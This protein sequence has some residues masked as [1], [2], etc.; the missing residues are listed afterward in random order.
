ME[1][2]PR[3]ENQPTTGLCAL[4]T[5]HR[6]R[7]MIISLSPCCV[8]MTSLSSS[9]AASSGPRHI[10]PLPGNKT[11][12]QWTTNYR[13]TLLLRHRIPPTTSRARRCLPWQR[14]RRHSRPHFIRRHCS[15][16]P[17][18]LSEKRHLRRRNC[19]MKVPEGS[20]FP[21]RRAAKRCAD[22]RRK[23]RV[24]VDTSALQAVF[25]LPFPFFCLGCWL[26]ETSAVVFDDAT[27][28]VTAEGYPGYCFFLKSKNQFN[29]DAIANVALVRTNIRKNNVATFRMALLL[30]DGRQITLS[31]PEYLDDIG[32]TALAVHR[33]LFGRG[34]PYYR[35]PGIF[36]LLL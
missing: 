27:R 34:N 17:S 3:R 11:P 33:F 15:P 5:I 35:P 4:E 21:L 19:S 22:R 30:R 10:I 31:G 6:C 8:P 18:L 12:I 28:T 16:F 2:L 13:K 29:Y 14:R 23:K 1:V 32:S 26:S 9:H 36:E 25:M 20:N 7:K 24:D